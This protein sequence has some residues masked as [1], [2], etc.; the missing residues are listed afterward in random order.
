M[1]CP[2]KQPMCH[3]IENCYIRYNLINIRIGIYNLQDLF[4]DTH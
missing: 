2:Y 1:N 4:G 3:S